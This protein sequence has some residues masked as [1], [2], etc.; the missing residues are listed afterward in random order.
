MDLGDFFRGDIPA[1]PVFGL[2]E[3]LRAILV[4]S[5]FNPGVRHAIGWRGLKQSSAGVEGW[6]VR[7]RDRDGV[8]GLH[9]E[10]WEKTQAWVTGSFGLCYFPDPEEEL[11][12]RCSLHGAAHC[13]QPDYLARIRNFLMHPELMDMFGIGRLFLSVTPGQGSLHLGME[14]FSTQRVIC[15][16]GVRLERDGRLAEIIAPGG[17]DRDFP[18]F[19]VATGFFDVLAASVSHILGQPP[20][21][22]TEQRFPGW[23]IVNGQAG[24]SKKAA[25][26][27]IWC[28]HIDLG[29]GKGPFD[30]GC[31]PCAGGGRFPTFLMHWQDPQP[32]PPAYAGRPWWTAHLTQN[33]KTLDK[34]R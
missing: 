24:E 21:S 17:R 20:D 19:E 33:Y 1:D 16:E 2:Q 7:I 29:Y 26:G 32:V 6:T 13:Q 9:F 28:G 18:A 31:I 3:L 8:F 11:V 25:A 4:R 22:F 5:Q 34:K 23:E 15:P 12:E 14:S 27:D 30:A 10:G